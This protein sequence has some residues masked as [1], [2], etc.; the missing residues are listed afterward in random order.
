MDWDEVFS[1]LKSIGYDGW[2]TAEILPYPDAET[3]AQRTVSFL[4]SKYSA[5][6]N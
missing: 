3:A 4:K 5:Y 2:T 6:Y 1:A